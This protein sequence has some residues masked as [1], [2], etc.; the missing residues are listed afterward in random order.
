MLVYIFGYGK[1]KT[2][3]NSLTLQETVKKTSLSY[4]IKNNYLIELLSCI[5][6]EQK[7][8]LRKL[9]NS[10]YPGGTKYIRKKNENFEIVEN[11]YTMHKSIYIHFS[12]KIIFM[13]NDRGAS[14]ES[15]P[16]LMR[17]A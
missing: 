12:S 13:L 10:N 7:H 6:S 9:F 11:Q 14:V 1:L 4:T 8:Y 3:L 16:V 15:C 17:I 2:N 5:N